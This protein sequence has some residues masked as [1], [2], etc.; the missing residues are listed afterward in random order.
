[1]FRL[2]R[3]PHFWPVVPANATAPW[4]RPCDPYSSLERPKRRPHR[5]LHDKE[6]SYDATACCSI[7]T[8]ASLFH[9]IPFLN[10]VAF[11]IEFL[12]RQVYR[13]CLLRLPSLYFS[14]VWRIIFEAQ[15]TRAELN[16]I[17]QQRRLGTD[18]PIQVQWVPP[19]VSP[20]LARFKDEWEDFIDGLLREW[21][22]FNVVAALLL[23]WVEAYPIEAYLICSI[24]F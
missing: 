12:V 6:G 10:Y 20:G 11:W 23:S 9:S 16:Q 3:N 17:I 19:V 5:L 18:F 4:S 2:R 24:G 22:T 1:M 7:P 13:H 15:V 14:R 8:W 21:K